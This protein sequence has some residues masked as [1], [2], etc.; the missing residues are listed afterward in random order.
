M[1]DGTLLALGVAG[2]LAL[3][4]SVRGSRSRPAWWKA[5]IMRDVTFPPDKALFHGGTDSPPTSEPSRMWVGPYGFYV[6]PDRATAE[7]YARHNTARFGGRSKVYEYTAGDLGVSRVLQ[8]TREPS[9]DLVRAAFDDGYDA[10]QGPRLWGVLVARKSPAQ[11]MRGS[12][13][14]RARRSRYSKQQGWSGGS[15]AEPQPGHLQSQ[16]VRRLTARAAQVQRQD[17]SRFLGRGNFGAVYALDD[18]TI[19]KLAA[20]RD[21][22]GRD[23]KKSEIREELLHEA[24][25][26]NELAAA[27]I[28]IVPWTVYVELPDG[29]PALV[30]ERGVEIEEPTWAE[31]AELERGIEAVERLGYFI[32][33]HLLVMRRKDGSV[34][35]ADVG[36]WKAPPQ[37]DPPSFMRSES[38]ADLELNR[39]ARSKSIELPLGFEFL[40]QLRRLERRVAESAEQQDLKSQRLREMMIQ[41]P[42]R[43]LVAARQA[44]RKLG[45]ET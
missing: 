11:M 35:V 4:G 41:R 33:D 7:E 29:T 45:L 10:V 19:V 24:G 16:E 21:M 2:A 22:H 18:D 30:R 42:R 8:V 1:K 28:R 38:D 26:S 12:R 27:G 15:P 39:W 3:V 31:V 20:K 36:I 25:I 32:R 37:G 34:F 9:H 44:R 14:V 40:P 43:Q 5:A 17:L 6:T 23:W 13:A